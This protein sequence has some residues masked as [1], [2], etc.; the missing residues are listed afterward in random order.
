MREKSR[1]NSRVRAR[2][3]AWTTRRN[4]AICPLIRSSSWAR[5][6]RSLSSISR[7]GSKRSIT[8]TSA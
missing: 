4:K 5:E 7:R 2:R 1:S 8:N 3:R 6:L